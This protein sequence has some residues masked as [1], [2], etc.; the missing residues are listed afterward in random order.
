[1][2]KLFLTSFETRRPTRAQT[3][4]LKSYIIHVS[5]IFLT[6]K[7]L[8]FIL[9]IAQENCSYRV[10]TRRPTRAQTQFILYNPKI[11]GK[12][13]FTYVHVAGSSHF[14]QT[15]MLHYR[16]SHNRS[17]SVCHITGSHNRFVTLK[18]VTFNRFV[19]LKEVTWKSSPDTLGSRSFPLVGF[20]RAIFAV[21]GTY[22]TK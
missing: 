8:K 16:K 19:T 22:I 10:N 13:I 1:M 6:T 18:E 14:N 17:H 20:L 2:R 3:Q 11:N 21:G 7:H 5:T 15:E 12:F 4:F 9:S